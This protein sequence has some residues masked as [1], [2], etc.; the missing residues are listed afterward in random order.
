MLDKKITVLKQKPSTIFIEKSG[1]I[2]AKCSGLFQDQN[3]VGTKVEKGDVLGII[4]DPFGKFL[5]KVKSPSSGYVINAN[6][7][8]IVYEGDAIYHISNLSASNND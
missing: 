4:T 8:P 1:W 7:S 2:R 6:H 5:H 3:L